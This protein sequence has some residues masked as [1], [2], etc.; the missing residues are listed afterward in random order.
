MPALAIIVMSL[1]T[2]PFSFSQY[3]KV[4]ATSRNGRPEENPRNAIVHADGWV[5]ACQIEGFPGF[6]AGSVGI[7]DDIGRV[8][9]EAFVAVD[10]AGFQAVAQGRRHYLIV[11][12]PTHVVRTCL[13]SVGPP[14]V[15][16]G[17]GFDRT[18]TVHPAALLEQ[19][20]QPCTFFRKATGV[21]LVGTPVLDVVLGVDDVP[22]TANHV[23]AA[24]LEPLIEDRRDPLH[25]LELE[26]LAFVAR[27]TRGHIQRDHA[28]V[29]KARLDIAPFA[30]ERLPAQCR[31]H[32]V[33]LALGID[34]HAAVA[35]LAARIAVEAMMSIGPEHRVAELVFLCLGFLQADHIGLLLA[36]PFE[37]ALGA[38]R[39]DA[40]GV[41][42][43]DAHA[44]SPA[45][46]KECVIIPTMSSLPA[47]RVALAQA[48]LHAQLL[49]LRV[50]PDQD[51]F[52]SPVAVTLADALMCEGSEPMAIL[53]GDRPIGFYR[54]E[55]SVRSIAGHDVDWPALGLR[56]FFIDQDWQGRGL[57]SAVMAAV[58]DDVK[59]RH[60]G[61]EA[62]V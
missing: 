18:E 33:R 6:A 4:P 3:A 53:L 49:Q 32:F 23:I 43:D 46:T 17:I 1:S 8:I 40:V 50:R 37:H 58:I 57:G 5:N 29:A 56:S 42:A 59:A 61:M 47:I 45:I 2:M 48:P 15:F 38:G 28:E 30:I 54:L 52:V 14:G 55:E 12:P 10:R 34:S 35:L 21:F 24:A 16:D 20:V 60:P 31:A 19:Q 13:P 22:V 11:D 39:T 7:V 36:Q 51:D 41:E 62:L 25:H 26:L 44:R 27:R 9:G